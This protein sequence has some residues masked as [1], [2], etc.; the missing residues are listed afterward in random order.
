MARPTAAL[1]SVSLSP[2]DSRQVATTM[3]APKKSHQ[4]AS[5]RWHCSVLNRARWC[6]LIRATFSCSQ[7]STKKMMQGAWQSQIAVKPG[8]PRLQSAKYSGAAYWT[9]L[10]TRINCGTG[11]LPQGLVPRAMDITADPSPA[12][13]SL[14]TQSSPCH[15][16]QATSPSALHNPHLDEVVHGVKGFDHVHAMQRLIHVYIHL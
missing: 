13:L 2:T 15:L 10:P 14:L 5:H 9:A 16:H 11:C 7:H 4:K 8:Q 1:L 12:P 6:S 3:M